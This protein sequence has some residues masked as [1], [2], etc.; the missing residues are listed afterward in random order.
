MVLELHVWGPAFSLPSIDAQCLATIA[1]LSL[2]LPKDAWV[3]VASSDPSVSPTNELPALRND[4]TW[5][6]RFRNIVDYLRQYSSG[7]W[8]LDADLTGLDRADSIAF[9]SFLD[10]QF[11]PLLALSLYV[12]SQNYYT[13]VLPAY[14]SQILT[15][16]STWLLPPQIR[17]AAKRA[18][19]HLG[20]SSLDLVALEE[21]RK[22]EHSAAVAAGRLP[23]SLPLLKAT[24]PAPTTAGLVPSHRFRMEAVTA[25]AFE[26]L[27]AML[28][29]QKDYLLGG[30]R[31]T[32]VD[33]L[34]LGYGSLAALGSESLQDAWLG[35]AMRQKAPRA[36]EWVRRMQR[37]AGLASLPWR[38]P[39]R[40]RWVT[41]GNTLWNTVADATPIWREYRANTRMHEIAQSHEADLSG[42]EREAL[43]EYA[44]GYKKDVWLSVAAVVGGVAALVG[45]MAHV[46]LLGGG[47]GDEEFEEDED[48]EVEV[49]QPELPVSLNATDFLGSMS[50]S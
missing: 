7:D 44:T 39:E 9:T 36:V 49:V 26:P 25:A 1:Y 33:C 20:L 30:D 8:D 34:L 11:P 10:T 22:R 47:D 37:E 16:P 4:N 48:E 50:F 43:A 46:G 5:V 32:S 45:Y 19:D 28:P 23:A 12:T 18:S 6:S 29:P 14:S 27:A 35:E 41:V 24:T 15:W 31:P 13:S 21:D 2:A 42:E 17:A 38:Q 40:P 3:L